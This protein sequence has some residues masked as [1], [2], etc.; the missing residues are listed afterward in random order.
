MLDYPKFR[1]CKRKNYWVVI[2]PYGYVIGTFAHFEAARVDVVEATKSYWAQ[3]TGVVS[4][5]P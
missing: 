5:T 4:C 3:A 2:N 1:V